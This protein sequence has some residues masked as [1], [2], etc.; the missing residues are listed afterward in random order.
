MKTVTYIDRKG[1]S[2]GMEYSVRIPDNTILVEASF[3]AFGWNATLGKPGVRIKTHNGRPYAVESMGRTLWSSFRKWGKNR[4]EDFEAQKA[5]WD[6]A[7]G[8]VLS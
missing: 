8:V 5:W 7:H 1:I 6:H 4:R 3:G 2:K